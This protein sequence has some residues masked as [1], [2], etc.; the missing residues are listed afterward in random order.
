[1]ELERN[2]EYSRKSKQLIK[3]DLTAISI[4]KT[5]DNKNAMDLS[6]W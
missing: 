1:M 5:F 4:E 6:N 2:F 3:L